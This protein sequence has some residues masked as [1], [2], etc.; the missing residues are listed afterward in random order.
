MAKA[1]EIKYLIAIKSDK[2]VK[3]YCRFQKIWY[4]L[5]R[6]QGYRVPEKISKTSRVSFS[7]PV[8]LTGNS[9]KIPA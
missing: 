2:R 4:P 3:K 8:A 5:Y 7:S 1:N 9:L 6:L